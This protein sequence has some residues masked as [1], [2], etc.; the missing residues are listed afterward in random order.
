[1][2]KNSFYIYSILA[3]FI[4]I[5]LN[6]KLL[7]NYSAEPCVARRFPPNFLVCGLVS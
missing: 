6:K 4:F 2:K 1:M 3:F 5:F 7:D